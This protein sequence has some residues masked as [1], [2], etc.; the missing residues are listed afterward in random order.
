MSSKPT[1]VKF[2][3]SWRGYSK[4]EVAGFSQDDAQRLV[5][6]EVAEL[7]GKAKAKNKPNAAS[8]GSAGAAQGAGSGDG[9]GGAADDDNDDN[10]NDDNDEK[11]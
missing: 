2:L 9:Q 3:K 11:P 4:D 5:D 10:D 1:V 7:V 8:G 6:G